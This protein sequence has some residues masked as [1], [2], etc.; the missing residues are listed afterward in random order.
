MQF[1]TFDRQ[2]CRVL[3]WVGGKYFAN[4]TP[5]PPLP[6]QYTAFINHPDISTMSCILNLIFFVHINED[7]T[8]VPNSTRPSGIHC[9]SG[10][11]IPLFVT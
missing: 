4:T 1:R 2:T 9:Y 10:S 8:F 5:L 3:L 6:P 7:H 11:H